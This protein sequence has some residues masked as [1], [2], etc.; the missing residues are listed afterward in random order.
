MQSVDRSKIITAASVMVDK[1]LVA[2]LKKEGPEVLIRKMLERNLTVL[3][4]VDVN[5]VLVG[6]V[7]LK[8]L[9]RLRQDQVK[10]IESV[11]REEVHSVLGDTI[12]ED[13]LPLMTRTNS[14]IWVVN[15][16]REFQGVVPLSSLIYEVTGKNKQEINEII[17]NAIE[18]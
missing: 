9:L 11:V 5:N 16:A 8:D 3:P 4:V 7:R 10:S 14:P 17:Q 13:I 1:P 18:L 12:L 6:E 15:E 2:R